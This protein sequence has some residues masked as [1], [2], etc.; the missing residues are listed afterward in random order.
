L[1][2]PYSTSS[3]DMAFFDSIVWL[4]GIPCSI[5]SDRDT[6]FTSMFGKELSRGQIDDELG[7]SFANGWTISGQSNYSNV[8][9]MFGR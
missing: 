3:V 5:V 9:K 8:S 4:H 7:I 2:H 6:I 1:S